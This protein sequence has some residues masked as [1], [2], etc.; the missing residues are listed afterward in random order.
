MKTLVE[1]ITDVVKSAFAQCNYSP[2]YGLVTLSNRPDLCQF[3]CNGALIAA[4]KYG[5]TPIAIATEITDILK[6]ILIL[7]KYHVL[8]LDLLT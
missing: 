4:K 2:E 6:N 1:L 8:C 5:K 3:Q 7:R